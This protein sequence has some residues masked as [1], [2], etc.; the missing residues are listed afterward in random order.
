MF[1]ALFIYIYDFGTLYFNIERSFFIR[2][3]AKKGVFNY[4]NTI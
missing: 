1:A 2:K 3:I 4:V